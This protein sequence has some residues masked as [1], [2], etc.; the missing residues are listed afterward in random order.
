MC[1]WDGRIKTKK[2]TAIGGAC[3]VF[4]E[5][6][7]TFRIWEQIAKRKIEKRK[8][9]IWW[10]Q[11]IWINYRQCGRVWSWPGR[12]YCSWQDAEKRSFRYHLND[13]RWKRSCRVSVSQ[14]ASDDVA[15]RMGL[16]EWFTPHGWFGGCGVFFSGVNIHWNI[17]FQLLKLGM[18]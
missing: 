18:E 12:T 2:A 8:Y 15:D 1:W 7:Q 10:S 5:A 14:Y 6:C 17:C 11:S 16:I 3:G 13:Q 4:E 9:S